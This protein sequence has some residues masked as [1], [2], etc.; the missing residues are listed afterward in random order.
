MTIRRLSLAVAAVAV[1]LSGCQT[2]EDNPK[3][4]GGTVLGAVG[5]AVIGSQF[6]GGSGRLVGTA[7]GTLVGAFIGS[8]IGRSLDNADRAAMYRAEQ[9]A[10]RAP[11]GQRITWQ[12]PQSGHHGWITPTNQ[13]YDAAGHH[14]RE[15]EQTI[16]VAGRAERGVGTACQQP[17]G[18]WRIVSG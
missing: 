6:G 3:Q 10:Y 12:N 11:I 4:F 16:Y 9:Q 1:I 8:E 2:I 14:C 17:D 5:G 7:V 18:T 15:F 13:G